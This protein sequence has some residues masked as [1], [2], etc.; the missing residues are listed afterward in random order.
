MAIIRISKN[1]KHNGEK[2]MYKRKNN[3]QKNIYIELKV[4]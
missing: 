4:E 3:D 1:S 2:K